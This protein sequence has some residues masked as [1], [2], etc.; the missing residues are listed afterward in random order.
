MIIRLVNNNVEYLLKPGCRFTRHEVI[1]FTSRDEAVKYITEC[2]EKGK[3]ELGKQLY[4]MSEQ[5]KSLEVVAEILREKDLF[6]R[7]CEITMEA[8]FL[9]EG[10][11]EGHKILSDML[12]KPDNPPQHD[13][14]IIAIAVTMSVGGLICLYIA[15]LKAMGV[16]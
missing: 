7:S 9:R 11:E 10:I 5:R 1:L 14:H 2:S 6:D 3:E 15:L 8:Q 12:W 13:W 4:L 16:I